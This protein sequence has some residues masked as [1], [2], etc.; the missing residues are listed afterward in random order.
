MKRY[1][2]I[3]RLERFLR[4]IEV[5]PEIKENEINNNITNESELEKTN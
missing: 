4:K 5:Y 1:I 3:T 2:E